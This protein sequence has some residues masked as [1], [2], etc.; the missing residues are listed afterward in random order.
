MFVWG[1]KQCGKISIFVRLNFNLVVIVSL[2]GGQTLA[3]RS[4]IRY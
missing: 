3:L 1:K 2:S 4:L